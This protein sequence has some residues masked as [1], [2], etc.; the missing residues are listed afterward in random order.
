MKKRIIK[1][2]LTVNFINQWENFRGQIPNGHVILNK[3][4]PGCGMTTYFLE[5]TEPIILAS[6]RRKL[7][8][9]KA[10]KMTRE[11]KSFFYY[12]AS[13]KKDKQDRI[14]ENQQT[15][16]I[17]CQ[18]L[19]CTQRP[20]ILVTFD[21]LPTLQKQLQL[22]DISFTLVVDEFH[23]MFIDYDM[24]RDVI[25]RFLTST[26]MI[27][28]VIYL[29]ATPIMEDYLDRMNE[30]RNLPY[31]EL[32]WHP[33]KIQRPDW[34]YYSMKSTVDAVTD[35][36]Q[37][38]KQNGGVFDSINDGG[39]WY[40]SRE[41]VFFINDVSNI[42]NII[43]KNQLP[44]SE[45]NILVAEGSENTQKIHKKLGT[46]YHIGD[47]PLEGQPHKTYTFCSKCVFFGCD[48]CST[49]ASTFVFAD[50]TVKNMM[51]DIAL[52]L[53]QIAGRQRLE[54]N[55]F[56]DRMHIFVKYSAASELQDY[57]EYKQQQCVRENITDQICS[58]WAT[59]SQRAIEAIEVNTNK[60]PYGVIYQD[61]T[62]DQWV[63]R[64]SINAMIS[65]DRAWELR[66][67]VYRDRKTFT[68]LMQKQGIYLSTVT[69]LPSL[70][71]QFYRDFMNLHDTATQMRMYC[72][73][74]DQFPG[75]L[76]LVDQLCNIPIEFKNYYATFGTEWI[77]RKGF[78]LSRIKPE[79]DA[80]IQQQEITKQV[81]MFFVVGMPYSNKVIKEKLQ[82]IY[83][84]LGL[85]KLTAKATDLKYYFDIAVCKL[86]GTRENGYKI[87]NE[88]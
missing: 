62:N 9:N 24:K 53:P 39:I 66:N 10:A 27:P 84:S 58:E 67:Y 2:P 19:N 54:T 42:V 88:K 79:Y 60:C 73:F 29:S 52:D 87:L 65:E 37:K 47:I 26:R 23:V 46:A 69:P 31:I 38:T 76:S 4:Y 15:F 17:L 75:Y 72:E 48:F 28:N 41:A 78:V 68:L 11:G 40:D 70:V 74:F 22:Y 61:A 18:Y 5:S 77:A 36:I 12:Q 83:D 57:Q 8:D 3:V 81:K 21:S 64:K 32:S 7:L 45:V 44:P 82:V 25:E 63:V 20:K 59:L 50:A 55:H 16:Q 49:N 86:Q 1:V 34:R 80:F 6:P 33:S 85:T 14:N 43:S 51:N 13:K 56:K 35:I 30:F 71:E